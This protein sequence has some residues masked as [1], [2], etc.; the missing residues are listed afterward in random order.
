MSTLL[1]KRDTTRPFVLCVS[2]FSMACMVLS[3]S[4][5]AGPVTP[6]LCITSV[7]KQCHSDHLVRRT[8]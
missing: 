8:P 2:I 3:S 5:M 4:L 6:S 7:T 1:S